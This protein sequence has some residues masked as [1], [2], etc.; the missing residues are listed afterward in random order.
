MILLDANLLIYSYVETFPQHEAAHSWFDARLAA[1]HRVGLPWVSLLGF[2]RIVT[3]PRI[4]ERPAPVAGAWQ[5][6]QTWLG[7]DGAWIP[8]PTEHHRDILDAFVLSGTMYGNLIP[9]AHLA[10]IAIGH[11]LTLCS[12]DA[13]FARF[14]GLRW[15]NPLRDH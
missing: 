14:P 2:L 7:A 6:V 15:E 13:D 11:G 10:A 5:Q 1:R 9:D 4:F 3:N 8:E 12:A